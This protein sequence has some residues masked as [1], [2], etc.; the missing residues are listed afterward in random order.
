[1]NVSL[2]WLKDHLDLSHMSLQDIDDLLT[3]A[4]VEVEGIS[5]KGVPSDKVVVAQ[6]KS[7]EKHPDADKL[8]VCMVDAGEA[9]LR[10][11]VCGAQN[12]SVG[13]KVP[14]ALPGADLGGG[15]VIKDGKLRGVESKG[16]LCGPDEIG[17]AS[18][19][20]GLMILSED[21]EIGKPLQ[22]LFETDTIIEVEVTP[23]RPDLLSH[24]GMARELAAL[25][26]IERKT[27]DLPEPATVTDESLIKL[28][29][30]DSCPLYTA[31]KISGVSVGES[32]AWL[33]TKLEAIGL[34][35]IN[36]VVDITNYALHE[37][38]HPLHAFDAA[39]VDGALDIRMAND[40]EIFKALDEVDY[41]L[42]SE[43]VV[44]SDASG[45]A[46]ALGGIMGGLDSGVSNATTDIILEAAYFTPSKIRRTSRRLIL[47][48][49]SSYRFER[50]SDAQ[51]V[52]KASAFAASLI[53][54]LAG[55]KMEAA[56]ATAGEAPQ[57]NG[58]VELDP[59]K[60]KQLMGAS[61]TLEG[62]EDILT[63][64]GLEKR[65]G[66]RWSVPSYRLDLHRH[67]DLVEEIARV[68]GLDNVPSRFQ[69][70]FAQESDVDVTY[71]Y[72]M[73]LRSTLSAVGFYETQTIKL[74]AESSTDL[75]VAQMDTALA[76]RPLQ[77]GDVIRVA[78]PLSEDH[79]VMRPSLTP[80]LVASAARN[81][82]QGAKSLRFFEIGR[83]FRNVGGGKATD[84]EADSLAMLL[85]GERRPSSWSVQAGCQGRIDAFDAKAAIEALMPNKEIQFVQRQRDGFIIA[86][87]VQCGGKPIGVFAQ[88]S[89][90]K[91]RD[92]GIDTPIYLVELDLKKCQQL[93]E[94]I[95]QVDELPQ[96]PGSSR[97]AAM[98]APAELAN[99]EIEK[100]LKKHNERL[101]VSS[102][103][104][105]V[106]QDP[107]GT[108]LPA[109][110]KSIAYTFHYR[111]PE[112][113]LKAKEVDEAHQKLLDGLQKALPVS[114]R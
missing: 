70:S 93:S 81:I 35:P 104:F 55:G 103:C 94:G 99:A 91:C 24:T 28:S 101:L 85:G 51:A 20:D 12:Y 57:L 46:L 75:T 112:R 86:A 100:V 33:K 109:D 77:D 40:G 82:R 8:K 83:Q 23:N 11:I 10:Q 58:E 6:V 66:N 15:F 107:T 36:N 88:L 27:R 68:H 31:V 29:A 13:D 1:M 2:N 106:F 76:L 69:A 34:R 42:S 53:V 87:D 5:Q 90:A 39:K 84:L 63:R 7:A 105:D 43:D 67:I 9:E 47:S 38:G 73:S 30:P 79:A 95:K 108:K 48:S 25:A 61:V 32:P 45:K 62:A 4:G 19:D 97:D 49:D 72:Q 80:G 14:C 71:D 18:A 22:D 113:T 111:S 114:Y 44:I 98:E 96:F 17:L 50:G 54:E 21:L 74:I 64:L 92:L 26:G 37:L 41:T 59:S 56:T 3:F 89:P 60:L 110:K 78:L 102:A 16:M 65:E 52:L